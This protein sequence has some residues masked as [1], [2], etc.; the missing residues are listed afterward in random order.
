VVTCP[1]RTRTDAGRAGFPGTYVEAPPLPIL[2]TS[3]RIGDIFIGG[4]NAEVFNPIA[5]EFKA[6][7]PFKRTM[8][9]TL[10]NGAADTGYIPDDASY[11]QNVFEVVSSRLKE[12]CAQEAINE[13][14]LD[15]IDR[16]E[17]SYRGGRN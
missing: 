8:M 3:L 4:V 9:A 10:T 12:G 17:Q 14:L 2:L 1:G 5:T 7:S 16:S 11:A 15:L 13:G 6:R